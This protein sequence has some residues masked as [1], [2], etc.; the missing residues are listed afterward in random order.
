[1]R[2]ESGCFIILGL[3]SLIFGILYKLGRFRAYYWM[4]P[5]GYYRMAPYGLIPLGI[6]LLFGGIAGSF[7]DTPWIVPLRIII[8]P[9]FILGIFIY[10][11]QP[12]FA[13][14]YWINWLEDNHSD[15]LP[16]LRRELWHMGPE[17]KEIMQDQAKLESWIEEFRRKQ[18][19]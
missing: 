11:F 18:A 4:Q 16:E 17:R 5:F 19:G 7:L 9:S 8:V 14:P 13:K 1:M 3:V 2:W 10:L 15:I 6:S 12:R